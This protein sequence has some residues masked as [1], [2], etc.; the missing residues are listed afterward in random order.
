MAA[1]RDLVATVERLAR[2]GPGLDVTAN[3][4]VTVDG[5]DLAISTV[6][7]RIRVQVPSVQAGFRLLRRE[8]ERL[9]ALSRGLSEAELTAEIRVG[10]SVIAVAGTDAKPGKLSRLF[11]LGPVEVRLRSVVSAALRLK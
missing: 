10:S 2:T 4:S 3:L 9:P 8:R 11:S 1:S 5:T 6:E 7:D